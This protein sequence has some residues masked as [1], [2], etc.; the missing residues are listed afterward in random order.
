MKKPSMNDI[1]KLTL[2]E[3]KLIVALVVFLFI[4]GF[5]LGYI[6]GRDHGF[7]AGER[8]SRAEYQI[9]ELQGEARS[10]VKEESLR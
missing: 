9:Q 5:I 1:V 7:S 2:L 8:F 10:M 3:V 4:T 6:A